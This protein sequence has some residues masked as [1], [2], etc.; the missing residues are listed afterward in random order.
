MVQAESRVSRQVELLQ[1]GRQIL[2]QRDVTQLVAAQVYAL[3]ARPGGDLYT[4]CADTTGSGARCQQQ[5][6]VTHEAAPPPP[7]P[8]SS[9]YFHL[10]Q[11]HDLREDLDGVGVGYE[12]VHPSA[13]HDGGGHR[14]QHVSTQVHLLQLLQ[15]GHFTAGQRDW[16]STA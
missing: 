9:T 11:L 10:H 14:L 2:R 6:S 4:L 16:L 5:H 12:R 3:E 8:P 1:L 13:V 7:P 15:L